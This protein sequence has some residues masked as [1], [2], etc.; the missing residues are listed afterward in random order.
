MLANGRTYGDPSTSAG[1]TLVELMLAMV[2]S[3]FII[4]GTIQIF[5]SGKAAYNETQRFGALQS[6]IR[7]ISDIITRDIRGSEA[8]GPVQPPTTEFD[9]SLADVSLFPTTAGGEFSGLTLRRSANDPNDVDCRG[10]PRDIDRI[11]FISYRFAPPDPD[12]PG[13]GTL[14]CWSRGDSTDVD[15]TL[16]SDNDYVDLLENVTAFSVTPLRA[17]PVNSQLE[18]LPGSNWTDAVAIR[19]S[20]TLRSAAAATHDISFIVALRNRVLPRYTAS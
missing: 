5:I 14:Q 8:I 6:D 15:A 20:L 13:F 3:L 2:L 12:G 1:F 19:V 4:G 10:R 7:F 17:N 18:I 16:D 9:S 11:M